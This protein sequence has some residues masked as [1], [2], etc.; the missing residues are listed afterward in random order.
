MADTHSSPRMLRTSDA[1]HYTGLSAST[2][3]KLRLTGGG[4]QYIKLGKV[5]VYDPHC[6]DAWLAAHRRRSTSDRG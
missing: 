1:A 4:P 5:V 2:L 6:L 3:N